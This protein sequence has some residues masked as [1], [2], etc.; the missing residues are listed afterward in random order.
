MS[1]LLT[2]AVK[3]ATPLEEVL[4][5]CE[6]NHDTDRRR[7]LAM[8]LGAWFGKQHMAG[9]LHPDPHPGN[10]LVRWS[11][12]EPEFIWLDVHAV[13]FHSRA[14]WPS[15]QR[16]FVLFNRWFQQRCHRT[17]RARFFAAY[18]A[19]FDLAPLGHAKPFA[20]QLEEA[21]HRKN[22]RHWNA[23]LWRALGNSRQ[24]HRSRQGEFV[25]HTVRDMAPSLLE[26]WRQ[27]LDAL[28]DPTQSELLKDSPSSTVAALPTGHIAKR[29]RVKN[30]KITYLN[31]LRPSKAV[32]SWVYGHSLL[33]RG[34]PTPRPVLM[35]QRY[36]H[37]RP[38][39]GYVIFEAI[40][41]AADLAT[42]FM[43]ASTI[44]Q[45]CIG[46]DLARLLR[47]LHY[48]GVSH[49]D[50][51]A[52][53]I[54]ISMHDRQLWL[55]DLVGVQTANTIPARRRVR[56]LTRLNVSF[57]GGKVRLTQKLCFL[58]NYLH[59]TEWHTWKT[60]WRAIATRTH[61]KVR[62]NTKRRRPLS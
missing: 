54:L 55:I 29:F 39:E 42:V 5:L 44:E 1:L 17:D 32:R 38:A 34:L 19:N 2:E 61:A 22:L 23:K 11:N 48:R 13:A 8:H 47:L 12:T 30:A 3:G 57:L 27:D 28:F 45:R 33:S 40:P 18:R 60:W 41:R 26:H 43:T 24:F 36:H 37:G 53:N 62:Q 50:L 15:L 14:P 10:I 51:K 25:V 4:I 46:E 31:L 35:A 20:K 58:L 16:N 59:P 52:S 7:R 6:H 56:D 21:T 9:V 49:R